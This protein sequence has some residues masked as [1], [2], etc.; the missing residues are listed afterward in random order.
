MSDNLENTIDLNR[1]G[2]ALK[3]PFLLEEILVQMQEKVGC[4]ASSLLLFD[5]EVKKLVFKVTTGTKRG[6]IKKL[7]IDSDEGVAGWVFRKGEPLLVTNTESDERFSKRFDEST[8][9]ITRSIMAIPL[10]L[11]DKVIGVLELLNKKHGNFTKE[12]LNIVQSFASIVSVVIENVELYKHLRILVDKVK[13]LENYQEV[14]L[15][16][17]TDGVM[18]INDKKQIVS[19]NKSIEIMLK[20]D[21]DKIISKDISDFFESQESV[22][23]IIEDCHSRGKIKSL[24]GY[25]KIDEKNRV[26]VAIDASAI[27]YNSRNEGIVIVVRNLESRLNQEEMKREIIV[28]SDLACN[29]SHEFNTPLT[30]IQSGIQIIKR[31]INEDGNVKYFNIINDNVELLK[32]RIKIFLDYLKAEK[33]EWEVNPQKMVVNSF[34]IEIIN[35][36]KDKFPNYK[37]IL[38]L[39]DLMIHIYANKGQTKKVIEMILKNAIQYSKKGSIIETRVVPNGN[40]INLYIKD[41]G[42]GI[43]SRNIENLFHKFKRFSD[44]L[45]ETSG[46]LGIELWLAKYLLEKNNAKIKIRSKEGKGTVVRISFKKCKDI[47]VST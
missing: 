30:S 37:F 16:S 31:S 47:M 6:E 45:T 27:L 38:S 41:H 9:F 23:K 20:R 22:K 1:A 4:G 18:S 29:L 15:E 14:L 26:P 46:G 13:N 10:L 8:G 36:F 44:P 25:L 32:E 5:D 42:C 34:L 35:S 17:L 12:D 43:S 19:C 21:K 24:F 2:E 3:L 40:L 33:D 28:R 39:P 7:R 11:G